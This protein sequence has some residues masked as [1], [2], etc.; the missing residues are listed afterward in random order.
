MIEVVT[1]IEVLAILSSFLKIS[2]F[3]QQTKTSL[4]QPGLFIFTGTVLKVTIMRK[5]DRDLTFWD[6]KTAIRAN[7]IRVPSIR[8]RFKPC[9]IITFYIQIYFTAVFV[10]QSHLLYFP[11]PGP[12]RP[13]RGR[14]QSPVPFPGKPT[15]FSFL[16]KIKLT[17]LLSRVPMV[18]MK[19]FCPSAVFRTSTI[20]SLLFAFARPST[21]DSGISVSVRN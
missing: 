7:T 21:T 17:M 1:R 10:F 20:S 9:Q 4:M 2:S 8:A 13:R 12:A 18:S 15:Y 16:P 6:H 11:F 19:D 14:G 3:R 5:P